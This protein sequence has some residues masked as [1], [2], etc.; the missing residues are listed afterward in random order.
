MPKSIEELSDIKLLSDK[1]VAELLSMSL[2]WVRK[3]RHLRKH[4]Q[5]HTLDLD[6][7]ML[8][9]A[10]RYRVDELK[11]WID[12]RKERNQSSPPQAKKGPEEDAAS[13]ASDKQDRLDELQ[14]LSIPQVR[15]FS[16][17]TC[18]YIEGDPKVDPSKCGRK[19]LPRSSYC[20]EHHKI[21]YLPK[22]RT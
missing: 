10:P 4:G 19:A 7:I 22:G 3:Q 8:G 14:K 2:A 21:C 16:K 11:A 9:S 6:P 1:E 18:Q 17:A 12:G 5:P 20:A 15:A 13:E